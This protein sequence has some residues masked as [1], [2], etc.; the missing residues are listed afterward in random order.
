MR[1]LRIISSV[2]LSSMLGLVGCVETFE[3][4]GNVVLVPRGAELGL[5]SYAFAASGAMDAHARSGVIAS[6]CDD[7]DASCEIEVAGDSIVVSATFEVRRDAGRCPSKEDGHSI[8]ATCSSSAIPPGTYVVH[9]GTATAELVIPGE[10]PALQVGPD[11]A[12]R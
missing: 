3:D 1:S 12:R 8:D 4:V 6:A 9:F 10:A 7:D 5:D 2:A 11:I